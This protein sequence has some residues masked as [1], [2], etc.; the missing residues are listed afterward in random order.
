MTHCSSRISEFIFLPCRLGG[1]QLHVTPGPGDLN[2][3]DNLIQ[4]S[5]YFPFP[6]KYETKNKINIFTKM[7]WGNSNH[8]QTSLHRA[9]IDVN[10]HQIFCLCVNEIAYHQSINIHF[11]I[12]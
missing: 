3:T 2:S 4:E 9:L 7:I 1:S 5:S 6:S 11:Q 12:V 8:K 10:V